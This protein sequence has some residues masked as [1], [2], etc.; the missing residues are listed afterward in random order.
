MS[1]NHQWFAYSRERCVFVTFETEAE[2]R[3]FVERQLERD[4]HAAI[5]S[6][7]PTDPGGIWG[8]IR[9]VTVPTTVC[10]EFVDFAIVA[11]A[12][13]QPPVV[14]SSLRSDEAAEFL[15]GG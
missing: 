10:G 14:E 11:P 7:W 9:G 15:G 2:A 13:V 12:D 4:R 5:T 8:Q 3:E 1:S 6:S